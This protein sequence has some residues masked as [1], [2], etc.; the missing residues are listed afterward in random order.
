MKNFIAHA[1]RLVLISISKWKL[2]IFLLTEKKLSGKIKI[3]DIRCVEII[4]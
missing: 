2:P 4:L 3:A 1:G